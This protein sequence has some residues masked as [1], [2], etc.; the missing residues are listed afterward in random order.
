V[1]NPVPIPDAPLKHTH[2]LFTNVPVEYETGSY[3]CTRYGLLFEG[4]HY[5][6]QLGIYLPGPAP[7]EDEITIPDETS[8]GA[9]GRE[10]A[11]RPISC[12]RAQCAFRGLDFASEIPEL[13]ERFNIDVEVKMLDELAGMEKKLMHHYIEARR[14]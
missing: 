2:I 5:Y 6:G 14:A 3:V 7:I 12:W 10:V 8:T 4:H 11:E 1:D 9:F 13:Q